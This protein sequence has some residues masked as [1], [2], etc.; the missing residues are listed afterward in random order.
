MFALASTQLALYMQIMTE[1]HMKKLDVPNA[2]LLLI[3]WQERLFPAMP[4]L[5]SERNLHQASTLTWLAKQ[6]KIPVLG[7]EQYPKGLGK[8]LPLFEVQ[9]AIAKVH[10]SAMKEP[11]FALRVTESGRQQVIIT[12]METHICVAQTCRDLLSA[13]YEVWVPSD[14]V[15]SRRKLDWHCGLDSMRGMGASITTSEAIL[16]ELLQKAGGSIFKEVSRRIR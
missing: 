15:L 1:V 11:D 12:G 2:L 14:A 13:G 3:D 4:E 10:F 5:I 8:T 9:D 6:L 16:F 7:S